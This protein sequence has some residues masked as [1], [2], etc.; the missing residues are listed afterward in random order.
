MTG[1]TLWSSIQNFLGKEAYY[2]D[3]R[4]WEEWLALYDSEAEFWVPAWLDDGTTT[5]DPKRQIS[6]IYCDRRGLSERVFRV[7]D[8]RS[9]ASIPFPRTCHFVNLLSIDEVGDETRAHTSW[10]VNSYSEGRTINYYGSAQYKL[11]HA[12][13][14]FRIRSKKTILVNDIT[15]TLMDF[16]S[17]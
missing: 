3:T 10:S 2:L 1:K 8:G 11:M 4:Q 17:I 6:L 15:D 9:A 14:S 7:R 16:Y 12:G 5:S 13:G